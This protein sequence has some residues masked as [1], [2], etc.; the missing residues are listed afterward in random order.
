MI[1]LCRALT[2]FSFLYITCKVGVY[3]RA[4][5]FKN[6]FTIKTNN[7][8]K[9]RTLGSRYY[10]SPNKI[11]F[12]KLQVIPCHWSPLIQIVNYFEWTLKCS[13]CTQFDLA[14]VWN[15]VTCVM[16]ECT[17]SKTVA[18]VIYFYYLIL[19]NIFFFKT[20]DP[21]HSWTIFP[22]EHLTF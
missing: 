9:F 13:N 4:S 15:R 18:I 14:G 8:N 20:D 11:E 22:T 21:V 7:K 6:S 17:H 2:I 19:F 10:K 16:V 3:F 5:Y 1:S 12:S